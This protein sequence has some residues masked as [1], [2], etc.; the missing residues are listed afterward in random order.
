VNPSAQANPGSGVAGRQVGP[1]QVRVRVRAAG[2]QPFDVGVRRGVMTQVPVTFPQQIGQ[3]YAGVVD[4]LGA[5]VDGIE[6]GTAV[7]G[8]TMLNGNATLLCVTVPNV[9]LK[10]AHLDFP[11]AAALAYWEMNICSEVGFQSSKRFSD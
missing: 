6:V 5:D 3:E 7:L 9:V 8:S 2:V 1:G 4:R 10:P 11:T